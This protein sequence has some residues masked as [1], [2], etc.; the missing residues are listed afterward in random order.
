MEMSELHWEI[1]LKISNFHSKIVFRSLLFS[2][3][4]S[5]SFPII[6]PALESLA[7][8]ISHKAGMVEVFWLSSELQ[9]QT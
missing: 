7:S 5:I 3:L 6:H 2:R 8:S 1:H 9:S 4:D